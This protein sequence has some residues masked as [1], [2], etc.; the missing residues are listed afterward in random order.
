MELFGVKQIDIIKSSTVQC[1]TLSVEK[2]LWHKGLLFNIRCSA[3]ERAVRLIHG[4][5][6]QIDM[7]IIL[8]ICTFPPK[9]DLISFTN[10]SMSHNIIIMN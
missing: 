7:Y 2:T 9:T 1:K 6:G 5:L 10:I 4:K 8:D 3:S